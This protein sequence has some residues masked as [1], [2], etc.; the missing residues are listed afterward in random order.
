MARI[1]LPS[2]DGGFSGAG[3]VVAA[4]PGT[5]KTLVITSLHLMT[6]G[7]ATVRLTDVTGVDANAA[8]DYLGPYPLQAAAEGLVLPH[9]PQGW[10]SFPNGIRAFLSSGTAKVVGSITYEIRNDT[11]PIW[12]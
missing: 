11:D 4:N 9:N 1:N 10:G 2:G 12:P 8:V 7:A 6:A 5:G 3:A